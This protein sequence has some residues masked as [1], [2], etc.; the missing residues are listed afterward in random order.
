[1]PAL[2]PPSAHPPASNALSQYRSQCPAYAIAGTTLHAELLCILGQP[3]T[4]FALSPYRSHS[5]HYAISAPLIPPV[6]PDESLRL[7]V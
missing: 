7:R 5:P 2:A 4:C 1:M 3:S 6:R